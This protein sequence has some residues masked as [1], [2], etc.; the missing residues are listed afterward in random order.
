MRKER[1]R[2]RKRG[3]GGGK[4]VFSSLTAQR[5]RGRFGGEHWAARSSGERSEEG[6]CRGRKHGKEEEGEEEAWHRVMM[7]A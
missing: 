7:V 3:R 6:Q 2:R 1:R 5:P 4:R